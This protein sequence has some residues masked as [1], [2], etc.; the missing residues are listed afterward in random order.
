MV[1]GFLLLQFIGE[2][3]EILLSIISS[4]NSSSDKQDSNETAD[5]NLVTRNKAFVGDE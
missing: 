2:I 1:P 5:F 4:K 3:S